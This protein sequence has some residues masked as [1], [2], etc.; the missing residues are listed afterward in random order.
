MSIRMPRTLRRRMLLP[1][2]AA[3]AVALAG[4]GT[5]QSPSTSPS[6]PPAGPGFPVTIDHA[7]GSTTITAAPQRVVTIGWSDQDAV[8]ALG[9]QPV[10]TTEW[11]DEQPGA[12]FPWAT[13]AAKGATPE[14]VANAGEISFEK[15]AALRPDLILALY[16]GLDRSEYDKLS[17]IAPTV[18]HPAEYD[19]FGAPWQETTVTIGRALGREAQAK[20]LVAGVEQKLAAVRTAHPQWAEKT[21]LVM[22]TAEAGTYG[23]FS[24]QDPKA[25]FFADLG[26]KTQPPWLAPRVQDNL[27]NVS[28]EEFT[29][30]DVD[31]LAWT[32]DPDLVATLQKDPIYNRLDVVRDGRV[33]YFDYTQAPFPGAAIT[34]NTVL[35]IPYA[36]DQVVPELEKLDAE[37]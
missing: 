14:I 35:S 36:L 9:V 33:S 23:V 10:G 3:L 6:A 18:A 34:F 27:A 32:S 13:A 20:D 4:C 19:A 37:P 17:A 16:E 1:L 31:R 11:F 8:L 2:A 29:L 24:P 7:L 25:R 15:V 22:A 26:F 21:M 28:A 12:V 5:A 30:L